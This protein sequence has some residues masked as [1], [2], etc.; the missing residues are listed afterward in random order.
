MA[1]P[2]ASGSGTARFRSL[3]FS[4]APLVASGGGSVVLLTGFG[5]FPGVARNAS[6]DLAAELARHASLRH[7]HLRFIADVLPVDWR[8]AP[9]RLTELLNR[10]RPA[11]A[12]HFGV[13]ARATGFVIETH[14]YN[15]TKDIPD[16]G[17]LLADRD[18]LVA[19]DRPR[20]SATVPVRGIVRALHAAGYAGGALIR[21]GA[22]PLQCRAVSFAALC[23]AGRAQN[24][25]RLHS[26]S[27]HA[28][29]RNAGRAVAHR[30]GSCIG[31][32]SAVD[33]C[34]PC[35]IAYARGS[36]I[37]MELPVG[38]LMCASPVPTDEEK[39]RP[40]PPPSAAAQLTA[41]AGAPR[42]SPPC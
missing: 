3:S 25:Q 19:G 35:P 16:D 20:R 12:L 17:G 23:D 31:W 10:H 30:L 11:V 7:S 4:T 1:S 8:E 36:P 26:H 28:R 9:V 32:W 41:T 29:T 5:R 18:I 22:V 34:L 14:A 24:A 21:P 13:S 39:S 6:A 27:G 2:K 40:C 42:C 15:V 37:L 33:G 38:I